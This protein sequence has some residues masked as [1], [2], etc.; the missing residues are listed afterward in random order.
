M[1]PL[2]CHGMIFGSLFAEGSDNYEEKKGHAPPTLLGMKPPGAAAVHASAG[3]ALLQLLYKGKLVML[4]WIMDNSDKT[5]FPQE[6]LPF[7]GTGWKS[8]LLKGMVKKPRNKTT[9][10]PVF[11]NGALIAGFLP[12]VDTP[13][14]TPPGTGKSS[15]SLAVANLLRLKVSILSLASKT[16]SDAG[17]ASLFETLPPRLLEDVDIAK[18]FMRMHAERNFSATTS[19]HEDESSIDTSG[20]LTPPPPT[21]SP[22]ILRS[23][24]RKQ[25]SPQ[26]T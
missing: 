21:P 14:G 5:W 10:S 26:E 19:E 9:S 15:L 3:I 7:S 17:R 25:D 11:R 24:R 16:P 18:P 6:I 2:L 4:E 12:D 8:Q 22:S 23:W 1:G 13:P 20:I